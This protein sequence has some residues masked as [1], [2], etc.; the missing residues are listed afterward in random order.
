M[1]DNFYLWV[2]MPLFSYRCGLVGFDLI[3]TSSCF[4]VCCK[5]EV[6]AVGSSFISLRDRQLGFLIRTVISAVL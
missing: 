5:K 1:C 3:F 4:S 2:H 6:K